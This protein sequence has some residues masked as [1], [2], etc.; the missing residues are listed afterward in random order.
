V[1]DEVA[2]TLDLLPT[3]AKMARGS[4]P[5]DRKID[6][7]DISSLLHSSKKLKSPTTAFYYYQRARLRA[8]RSG[9]WKLHLAHARDT[10]WGNHIAKADDIDIL[11]PQLFD[12]ENDIGEKMDLV[13]KYPKLVAKLLSLSGK[14]RSDLGDCNLPGSGQRSFDPDRKRPDLSKR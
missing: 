9:K 11:Q 12:L 6:G 13:Q 1:R 10:I 7:H 4:L 2:S 5:E 8:V 14:A 3:M